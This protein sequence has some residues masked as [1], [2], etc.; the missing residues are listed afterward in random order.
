[1]PEIPYSHLVARFAYTNILNKLLGLVDLLSIIKDPN[2]HFD[3]IADNNSFA[4]QGEVAVKRL[5]HWKQFSMCVRYR[6]GERTFF[7]AAV[8]ETETPVIGLKH[9]GEIL[10]K[11]RDTCLYS[12]DND[13]DQNCDYKK[14]LDSLILTNALFPKGMHYWIPALAERDLQ[15]SVD[16]DVLDIALNNQSALADTKFDFSRHE[17]IEAV[18]SKVSE[19]IPELASINDF[20]GSYGK[21]QF[22]DDIT[23][24]LTK[25]TSCGVGKKVAFDPKTDLSN[26]KEGYAV[27]LSGMAEL[28]FIDISTD[29]ID[30]DLLTKDIADHIEFEQS[31]KKETDIPNSVL[32]VLASRDCDL[33]FLKDSYDVRQIILESFSKRIKEGAKLSSA[34]GRVT[35]GYWTMRG[36]RNTSLFKFDWRN[37]QLFFSNLGALN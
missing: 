22:D 36:L 1:M 11:L 8:C 14:I 6:A 32:N 31:K 9:A 29:K 12:E 7:N 34:S 20:Y 4:A 17:I 3:I 21:F 18:L 28:M 27:Y 35:I 2:M 33:S 24:S 5:L 19:K 25:R 13:V 26:D 10:T 16:K 30:G 23:F 37:G 15:K